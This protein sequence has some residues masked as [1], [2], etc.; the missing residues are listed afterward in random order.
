MRTW[1]L[2]ALTL[3]LIAGLGYVGAAAE[4]RYVTDVLR[5]ALRTGPGSEHAAAAGAQSGQL[6]EVLTEE[7]DWVKVRNPTGD[8]GWVRNRYLTAEA[9]A[10]VRLELL[11]KK[12]NTLLGQSRTG[13]SDGAECA[14]ERDRLRS[15]AARCSREHETLRQAYDSLKKDAANVLELK[16]LL[17]NAEARLA[18]ESERTARLNRQVEKLEAKRLLR[19]FL[20]GA[21]VLL[22]G[23]LVGMTLSRDRRRS[24][25]L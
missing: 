6:L 20:T 3:T 2:L 17:E 5:L 13:Q 4:K 7:G 21:G 25:Y 1:L 18:E 16:A 9:P 8:E 19:W 11:E 15:E 24:S 22:L 14:L 10:V 12:Y 23:I